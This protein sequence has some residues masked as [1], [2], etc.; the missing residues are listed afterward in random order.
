MR[1]AAAGYIQTY[2]L[3]GLATPNCATRT[4]VAGENATDVDFGYRSVIDLSVTKTVDNATPNVGS[5]VV[6]TVTVS[7]AA[8][9]STATSVTVKD[10]LPAGLTY[11]SSTASQGSYS[12]GTGIWTV[13]TLAS[14]GAATLT[15]TATV[16]TAGVKTKPRR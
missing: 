8:G 9:L 2:D 3:D 4:V 13:G 7:N 5:N 15:I 10:V 6:F 14:G 12:S 1:R 11:V 16:A